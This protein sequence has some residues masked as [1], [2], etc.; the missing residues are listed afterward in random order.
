[1]VE[2][3]IVL[4]FFKKS[5]P[6]FSGLPDVSFLWLN[7]IGAIGVVLLAALLHLLIAR[8]GGES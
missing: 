8:R 2:A 7:A 5:I 4:L 6:F 3:F 1:V